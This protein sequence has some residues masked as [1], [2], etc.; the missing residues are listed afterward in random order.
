MRAPTGATPLFALNAVAL[1]LETTSL[2]VREA[3]IVQAGLLHFSKGVIDGS[4]LYDQVVDPRLPIPAQSTAIHGIT[5]AMARQSPD[6]RKVWPELMGKLHN[7][8][9]IGHTI[10]YDLTV[11]ENEAAR[12]DL[13]WAK[14]RSLCV[15]LLAPIALPDLANHSL[16]ALASWFSITIKDRHSALSDADAAARVFL[17][18]I[19]MLEER[20]IRTL[21]E[22]ERATLSRGQPLEEGKQ[23]GWV[24]PV[25]DPSEVALSGGFTNYDTYAYRH[26]VSDMMAK[27]P[28]VIAPS[29]TLQ[30]AASVMAQRAISSVLV[31][32]PPQAGNHESRYGILT[33]RDVMRRIAADGASALGQTA[34][35]L[36][37]SPIYT[38]RENAFVYRAFARMRRLKIRH[39]AVV[40]DER[41]LTG[42]ISAR[43]LLKMRTDPAITLDDAIG[44]ASDAADM[45]S[46]WATLPAVVQSLITEGLDAHKI[47]R[48][49]SEEIRSMTERAAVLAEREMQAADRGKPPCPYAVMVLGSGG[50]GES[51]LKPDQDNALVFET[52][53]PG[54][55]NDLWFADL[56]ERIARILNEAGIPYCDGG[57]M[58]KNETWRGSI[59]TWRA[60]I[61][62]WV[63][64]SNP[65]DLLNV[66]IWFDQIPVHGKLSLAAG[67][68]RESY[69]A[70]SQNVG[71]AKALG[72]G[73]ESVSSPFGFFGKIRAEN[74]KL[75]LKLHAL[76][77]L[78]SAARALAI[79]HN[80]AVH[81]T[82]A[83]LELLGQLEKGDVKLIAN[84]ARDHALILTLMLKSQEREVATGRKPTNFI[85]LASLSRDQM[86]EL[87]EALS[88]MQ[89]L[90][91]LV[92]DLMF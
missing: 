90:P 36:A 85:D 14:P 82:R 11:L 8:V 43:D 76:F 3:R 46:A 65:Q 70:A 31:C 13:P 60:R 15:R 41:L 86:A 83:R 7:R 53:E 51:L 91:D 55:D 21:A 75:D 12:H 80:L 84:L 23:A 54:S 77:P 6:L 40:D 62:E 22:A 74:N 29:H 79:R 1:D 32:D 68:F 69:A 44:E 73:L 2:D 88:R 56:G 50:R 87:K 78:V 18:M 27:N 17:A 9:M 39:L 16:D 26:T 92:R 4:S 45:A 48:I 33:E 38:I 10:A 19:P 34:G 52:G 59:D 28:V 81:S 66:D 5:N 20:G 42:M 49:V 67:L 58:A 24:R 89:M 63:N 35:N 30:E 57:I 61:A 37:I 64:R 72:A 25:A 71:F 47:T